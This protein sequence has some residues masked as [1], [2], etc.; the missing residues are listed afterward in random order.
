MAAHTASDL[1]H[2]HAPQS[3]STA[4]LWLLEE[5]GIERETRVLNFKTSEHKEPWYL[6]INPMGKVP[7]ISHRGTVVT[8]SAAIAM[9]LA[10]AFPAAGLA[11]SIGDPQRGSYLRWLVF[12]SAC[13]EPAIIDRAMKRE[14]GSP[15]MLPYGDAQTTIDVLA[16]ALEKG[17]FILGERFSAADVVVG[18]GVRWML[19]FKLLPERPEF[20]TY[21]ARLN[22]RPAL[23]RQAAMDQEFMAKLAE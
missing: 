18:S 22:E 6:A 19:M 1:I 13:V 16:K 21:A 5:L 2:F 20:T 3:R 10:D 12:N 15:A 4:T 11:P 7:A 14:G 8:E 23:R 17:P 9:Y